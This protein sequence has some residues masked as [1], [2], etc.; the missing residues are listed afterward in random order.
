[1][2]SK[3]LKRFV[4][5]LIAF[6]M[7]F[8]TVTTAFGERLLD[9]VAGLR[10]SGIA[11]L[12]ES[13]AELRSRGADFEQITEFISNMDLAVVDGLSPEAG[14][15]LNAAHMLTLAQGVV[16]MEGF[17]DNEIVSVMVWLQELP[18]VLDRILVEEGLRSP[19]ANL[20]ASALGARASIRAAF[21]SVIE[22]EFSDL[23]SGFAITA[24]MAVVRQIAEIPGVFAVTQ[25]AV[26]EILGTP[27][28]VPVGAEYFTGAVNPRHVSSVHN[29]QARISVIT[30]DVTHTYSNG[31]T[32]VVRYSVNI[33]ANNNNI[34]GRYVFGAGHNLHGFTLVYD[35]R[36]NGS[37]IAA[38]SLEGATTRPQFPNF[39]S[40]VS[41]NFEARAFARIDELHNVGLQGQ[42]VSVGVIDS[43]IDPEHPSFAH[44]LQGGWN[45]LLQQP[46][47]RATVDGSHGTHVAGTIASASDISLGVA[48]MVELWD[49]QVFGIAG[50]GGSGGSE[51][52]VTAAMEAFAGAR[53]ETGLPRVDI[54]NMSL[55]VRNP[56]SNTA[57]MA[58]HFARNNLVLSGVTVIVAAGNSATERNSN[59]RQP[60]T[61]TS[62]NASLPIAV[63]SSQFGS[64]APWLYSHLGFAITVSNNDALDYAGIFRTD[65]TFGNTETVQSTFT[66]SNTTG[67]PPWLDAPYHGTYKRF[68]L[69]FGENGVEI[70]WI[71]VDSPLA[72]T[73]QAQFDAWIAATSDDSLIGKMIA[74][75]R[76]I[77]FND[78]LGEA[79]RTG[80]GGVIM[81]DRDAISSVSMTIG[82]LPSRYG[83]IFQT[84]VAMRQ[85]L[86]GIMDDEGRIFFNPNHRGSAEVPR[87]FAHSS[88]IGPVMETA[89]IKPDLV[90]PGDNIYS[91]ALGGGYMLMGGTSMA[92][93]FVAGTAALL[94][95]HLR[96][97]GQDYSPETIRLRLMNTADPTVI[98]ANTS[99]SAGDPRFF[100]NAAGTEASV[101]EQG[102]G[103]INIF[104]AIHED[105]TIGV[106]TTVPTGHTNR[107]EMQAVL[108]SF[109]FG[110]VDQGE[111]V[112]LTATVTGL[113]NFTVN[114]LY[115]HDTR[116][117]NNNLDFAVTVEAT[118]EGNTFTVT[119]NVSEYAN[120][121]RLDGG[122]LFEGY[123]EVVG[124]GNTY[125]LPWGLRVPHTDPPIEF[126]EP[127]QSPNVRITLAAQE[128]LGM[129][130]PVMGISMWLDASNQMIDLF[131]GEEGVSFA[132]LNANTLRVP[133][134]A[135]A[136]GSVQNMLLI[137]QTASITV[138]PDAY[139]ILTI[140][141]Q[142]T[143]TFIGAGD[144]RAVRGYEF[145]A[146]YEYVFHAVGNPGGNPMIILYN[147]L[148]YNGTVV[149]PGTS[150]NSKITINSHDISFTT[151]IDVA[152][153]LAEGGTMPPAN[154]AWLQANAFSI[155]ASA[156]EFITGTFLPQGATAYAVIEPGSY[157]FLGLWNQG[158]GI[159]LF[160]GAFGSVNTL[161][162][163][164][165][166]EYIFTA[167]L[168]GGAMVYSLNR[169]PFDEEVPTPDF[170]GY[171]RITLSVPT[172]IFGGNGSYQ[173]WIAG[174]D[175]MY[176][177]VRAGGN[178]IPIG[179]IHGNADF[180]LP[181]DAQIGEAGPSVMP[182]QTYTIVIPAGFYDYFLLGT[183]LG[184]GIWTPSNNLANNFAFEANMH[185]IFTAVPMGGGDGIVMTVVAEE[186][187]PP[188]GERPPVDG[189][190]P[191][192]PT[193]NPE[194]G[195]ARVLA[196]NMSPAA[197]L[198]VQEW[199][200]VAFDYSQTAAATLASGGNVNLLDDFDIFIP[201]DF[202]SERMLFGG[203]AQNLNV[204]A[205]TYDFIWFTQ[206]VWGAFIDDFGTVTLEDGVTYI[207][208]LNQDWEVEMHICDHEEMENGVCVV[209][210]YEPYIPTEPKLAKI[211]I[212]GHNIPF[213]NPIDVAAFLAPA[214][215]MPGIDIPWLQG[216]AIG[217][218]ATATSFMI[219]TFLPQGATA[220]AII[221]AGSYDFL[222]LW[223]QGTGLGL[224]G[225][226]FGGISTLTFE[227]GFEYIFTADLV[228]GAMVFTLEIVP[229]A[230][231]GNV[232]TPTLGG[233]TSPEFVLLQGEANFALVG[234]EVVADNEGL[235]DLT[236][237]EDVKEEE[238]P[239]IEE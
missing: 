42:G 156:I 148:P 192:R 66:P 85:I 33:S 164:A 3:N 199:N 209:C 86:A 114:V 92:S 100:F 186:V 227:A 121:N 21:A 23:F 234:D 95:Q 174:G 46:V 129:Y 76:G 47:T 111:S 96:A 6:L 228:G 152:A 41:G 159:G 99:P 169:V 2:R 63:A 184:W 128:D 89:H 190:Q 118:I 49:A 27:V 150:P 236:Y 196:F 188:D 130:D 210:A 88:S 157:D 124:G 83:V 90:A 19:L 134:T 8:S 176:S 98:G 48:P 181:N 177:A 146:G 139:D 115:N 167:D 74:F 61:T 162:F 193:P 224:F 1:M 125:V 69:Y 34:R 54:V 142:N 40:S 132:W 191:Q 5:I 239:V 153:F 168:V 223:N 79:L 97:A 166:W 194:N 217:I 4:A 52:V 171:T 163:E 231:I 30:F 206:A 135:V 38:F 154:I 238:Y 182:T 216:N 230:G 233:G 70:V 117:S 183:E 127:G 58:S 213:V 107:G 64:N 67:N 120:N 7:A 43:G 197:S 149:E 165:G 81:I 73:T 11:E 220:Y 106:E 17:A 205:G 151:P 218:P 71:N 50:P 207:F 200:L 110:N 91:A 75:N 12:T 161:T 22:V 60:Y 113:N 15:A 208:V 212:V 59:Q 20:Q 44:N 103:F 102:A 145:L 178:Q 123:I 116:Y 144:F 173:M 93:P 138:E 56:D 35:V 37:N 53:P 203:W 45:F 189:G 10:E 78:V 55:G 14:Y 25:Q 141:M 202:A 62:S 68:P 160:G 215:T 51:A 198:G 222:G 187:A 137:G 201:D 133:P 229:F 179:L 31:T 18:T 204:P 126:P 24:P 237:D 112:S 155:P 140:A 185:Y 105:V 214:G 57:F 108:G 147:I 119:A 219:G 72:D 195:V 9:P 170:D 77:S 82:N 131:E 101:F 158:T 32:E 136:G 122:N 94:L 221:E 16:G 225:G 172:D 13:F 28:G 80:A 36:G 39:D 87:E 235:Q 109:N 180:S 65:G 226:A 232:S 175:W 26:Y 104:R 29:N 84:G 143:S 211:T